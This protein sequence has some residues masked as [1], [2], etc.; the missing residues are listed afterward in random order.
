VTSL[1]NIS[2]AQSGTLVAAPVV[3]S[4]ALAV[5]SVVGGGF[6]INMMMCL[7][8]TE[9]LAKMQYLNINH[10]HIASTIYAGMSSSPMP[11]WIASFNTLQ[12]DI[13]IF[14]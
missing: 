5:S 13:L 9:A 3:T 2:Q 10:S 8:T 11:N 12:Q 7:V 6:S 4:A 1:V 14:N